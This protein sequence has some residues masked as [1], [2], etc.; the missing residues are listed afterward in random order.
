MLAA[1]EFC[2]NEKFCLLQQSSVRMKEVV[3][4]A[5]RKGKPSKALHEMSKELLV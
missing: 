1:S 5:E 4:A 3:L 2:E